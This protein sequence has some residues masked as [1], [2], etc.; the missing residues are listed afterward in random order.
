MAITIQ[1]KNSFLS[2]K[3][4]MGKEQLN[5]IE[6]YIEEL[7][8]KNKTLELNNNEL[9]K[10]NDRLSKSVTELS[11]ENFGL[12]RLAEKTSEDLSNLINHMPRAKEFFNLKLYQ[13]AFCGESFEMDETDVANV[14]K[15]GSNV[16]N[17]FIE[18]KRAEV[19]LS[20][21]EES[22]TLQ[23][24][25]NGEDV[26]ETYRLGIVVSS[27]NNPDFPLKKE[28][29]VSEFLN[30]YGGSLSL[31]KEKQPLNISEKAD[32]KV[33]NKHSLKKETSQSLSL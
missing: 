20:N 31:D 11:E 18:N 27:N 8:L 24:L 29:E 9:R 15:L 2:N 6:K 33:N 10:E 23:F 14:F 21:N 13:D 22:A 17:E 12:T 16:V 28:Y 4:T 5:E 1:T 19:P 25:W 30:K 26:N 32:I 7:E 3:L